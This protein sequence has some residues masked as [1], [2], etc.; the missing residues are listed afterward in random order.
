[1]NSSQ[2]VQADV[3]RQAIGSLFL[4]FSET[5][6]D[7][8]TLEAYLDALADFDGGVVRDACKRLRED[9]KSR[10]APRPAHIREFALR[11]CRERSVANRKSAPAGRPQPRLRGDE[12]ERV[13]FMRS[14]LPGVMDDQAGDLVAQTSGLSFGR[15]L[16]V[17]QRLAEDKRLDNSGLM[18][19]HLWAAYDEITARDSE[20][21]GSAVI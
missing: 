11:I 1:M 16:R 21:S 5:K 14:N 19:G 18:A 13:N 9:W 4:I 2:Q 10:S 20:T 17:V 12:A 15:F 3:K 8:A 6:L 7:P